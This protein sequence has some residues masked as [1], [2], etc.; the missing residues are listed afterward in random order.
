[1]NYETIIYHKGLEISVEYYM[2]AEDID[3]QYATIVGPEIECMSLDLSDQHTHNS[4]LSEL[5]DTL[6]HISQSY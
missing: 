6:E 3:L 1:M 5:K 4:L 2:D